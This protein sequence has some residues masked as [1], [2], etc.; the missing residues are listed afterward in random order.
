MTAW[1]AECAFW[2]AHHI[3]V[4]VLVVALCW[5]AARAFWRATEP[6]VLA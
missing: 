6:V 2:P 4:P 5:A 1:N 3:V